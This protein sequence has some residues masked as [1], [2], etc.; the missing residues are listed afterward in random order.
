VGASISVCGSIGFV[1]LIVPHL[2][3]P[4]VKNQ[5]GKLLGTSALGGAILLLL[6]DIAVRMIPSLVELK[7]GVITSLIG[8]P[9][10]LLL[11]FQ[12]R[13]KML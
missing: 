6:S 12:M 13:K 5:P 2:L 8:A 9:F 7:L 11:I 4:W 3:R 1:G 10:F